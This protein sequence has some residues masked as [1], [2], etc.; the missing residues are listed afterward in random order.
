MKLPLFTAL[1]VLATSCAH[2]TIVPNMEG[3]PLKTYAPT[4]PQ[5][6]GIYRVTKPYPAFDQLGTISYV[7]ESDNLQALYDKIR[8]DAA[9]AGAQAVVDVKIGG[10]H[11]VEMVPQ[12]HCEPRTHCDAGGGN[13]WTEQECRTEE[14]PT[15]VSTYTISGTLIREK[16]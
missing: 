1:A 15:E 4:D 9:D 10:E 2:S 16:Q 13:C 3:G 5:T 7:A 11:H 8:R 14:V 12:Q 6:V